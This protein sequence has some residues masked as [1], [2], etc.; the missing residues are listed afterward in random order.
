MMIL[1][2]GASSS[3]FVHE[4]AEPTKPDT[5]P[6]CPKQEDSGNQSAKKVDMEMARKMW[7]TA[8]ENLVWH[9]TGRLMIPIGL[10]LGLKTRDE[11]QH[12]RGV[13]RRWYPIYLLVYFT[14]PRCSSFKLVTW[15][16]IRMR[17]ILL[18][19]RTRRFL[20]TRDSLPR[21]SP[22]HHPNPPSSI[23]WLMKYTTGKNWRNHGYVRPTCG[24]LFY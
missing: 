11:E 22:L 21:R 6:S 18:L 12:Q 4:A 7:K 24:Y 3:L 8:G 14:R 9:C 2:M 16:I 1:G 20:I 23:V 15:M 19:L 10:I 17:K 13:D 5:I